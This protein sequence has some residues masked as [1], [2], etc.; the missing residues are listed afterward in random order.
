MQQKNLLLLP[1]RRRNQPVA[2]SAHC[3]RSC[4]PLFLRQRYGPE[5]RRWWECVE[6]PKEV[7]PPVASWASALLL[8]PR[9]IF[10]EPPTQGGASIL[11]PHGCRHYFRFS[12][13]RRVEISIVHYKT[14]PG[15]RTKAEHV[16]S[17]V[18]QPV[19]NPQF[20][21]QVFDHGPH[22]RHPV[23]QTASKWPRAFQHKLPQSRTNHVGGTATAI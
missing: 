22:N 17:Q 19:F 13:C 9:A 14:R 2:A 15:L 8:A 4:A 20:G 18:P 3:A 6:A 21:V 7:M 23:V 16:P 1:A 5:W 12:L 10:Q 11:H